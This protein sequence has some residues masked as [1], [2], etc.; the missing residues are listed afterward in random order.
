M[1]EEFPEKCIKSIISKVPDFMKITYEEFQH[2][3]K[4][5]KKEYINAASCIKDDW[6]LGPFGG[7][8]RA[9]DSLLKIGW[10]QE[11]RTIGFRIYTKMIRSY[12]NI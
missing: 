2:M 4:E 11:K 10:I 9:H 7:W 1:Q 8:V 5:D 3:R 12:Q 6:A